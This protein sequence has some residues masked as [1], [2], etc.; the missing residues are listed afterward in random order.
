M[1]DTTPAAFRAIG[2]ARQLARAAGSPFL[3]PTHLLQGLLGEEEGRPWSLLTQAGVDPK[4]FAGAAMAFTEE[5]DNDNP[6]RSAGT[7]EVVARA[8][9]LCR[10]FGHEQSVASDHLLVALLEIDGE[11][12]TALEAR[13]LEFS[14]L[15]KAAGFTHGPPIQLDEPIGGAEPADFLEPYRILDAAANRAR[16]A[17][18]VLEDYVRFILDDSFLT[19]QLKEGRHALAEA[20]AVLPSATLLEARDTPGDVGT[21]LAARG[22]MERAA[23][24]DV[25]QANFKRLEESLRSLEEYSKLVKPEMAEQ[26]EA[27]RYRAYTLERTVLLGSQARERLAGADLYVLIGSTVCRTSVAGA[28]R[29]AAESGAQIIQLR[30]KGIGDQALLALA[31]DVRR[32][33][34]KAGALFI[35]NDRPDIARL[36][37]A[38]GVHLGQDD[39]PVREASRILGP[40]ALIG[41]STHNMEQLRQAILDGASYIGVGPVFPSSTK[42]FPALAGLEF[43]KTAMAET[44]LPAFAIGGI[45]AENVSAVVAAGAKRI[46][47]SAAVCGA[48]DPRL[49]VTNLLKALRQ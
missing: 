5:D 49:A 10:T 43:V 36:C 15:E 21:V 40:G 38:D 22:E 24:G 33:T 41:V 6:P 30:E 23:L 16:E 3:E 27:L 8:R 9:E 14:A 7:L 45:S 13:G 20:L 39:L 37:H 31:R 35:V 42:N 34:K 32:I 11:L 44:S 1:Y 28:A 46:A 12:R 2:F 18:R 4:S 48:D 47:V 25:V 17:F 29:D 19:A 26:I